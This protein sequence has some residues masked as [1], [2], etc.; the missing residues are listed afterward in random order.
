MGIRLNRDLLSSVITLTLSTLVAAP[1]LAE[2]A[3]APASKV[4]PASFCDSQQCVDVEFGSRAPLVD[5]VGWVLGIPRKILLWDRRAD[6]HKVSEETVGE[7]V[8]YIDH[9]ELHDVKVRVNQYHPIGEWKRLVANKRVGAGWRYTVGAFTTL[10]YTVLPGRLFGGD[11]YNPYTNTLSIYSDAPVLSLAEAAY[12]KD[13]H[14]R[15]LPGTYATLQG[16]PLVSLWHE[17]IATGEV[18]E[19][20]ALHGSQDEQEQVRRQLYARYGMEFGGAISGALPDGGV[21]LPI[22]GAASG[23]VA[24][25]V[26][27]VSCDEGSERR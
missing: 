25:A 26:E 4:T 16:F 10:G 20:V 2:K 7:V 11:H 19:Y 8:Q 13:V 5:G 3:A 17:T 9:R 21:L 22:V 27:Q 23:H 15:D 6:N 18:L 24:A 12:A 14:K 1:S